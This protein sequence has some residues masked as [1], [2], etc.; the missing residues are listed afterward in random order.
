[1]VA[2]TD[3][4]K[5][6]KYTNNGEFLWEVGVFGTGPSQFK[7]PHSLDVGPDG[8][9]YVV[10]TQ[11]YRVQVLSETGASLLVFGSW[12]NG[13]G[14]FQFPR[15][16]GV[17]GDGSMWVADSL[18]GVIQHFAPNGTFLGAFGT[19]GT[20]HNQF[21][22]AADVETDPTRVFVAN[23]DTHKVKVWTKSGTFLGAFG[24]GG[25]TP[26]RLLNPHGMELTPSGRLYVV[27][28]TGERVQE[29]AVAAP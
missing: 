5:I 22:R 20:G 18:R 19:L 4:H 13:N 2:D 27:E 6:K 17:D 8:R 28:Q 16:I 12:G 24:G 26:G 21:A 25:R 7:N 29:F 10:D 3:N 15:G 11:N 9:I 1:V 23:V 14:Q